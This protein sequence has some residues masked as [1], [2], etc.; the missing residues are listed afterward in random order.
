VG[1]AVFWNL[2]KLAEGDEIEVRLADG[3]VYR[4]RV[5]AKE[6]IAAESADVGKIVGPTPNEIITLITCGGSFDSGSRQYD[7]RVIVRA[8]RVL[9]SAPPAAVP[10]A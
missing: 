5:A 2:G 1:P 4:Y 3:T 7:Q 10:G 6:Q 9:E 8:E